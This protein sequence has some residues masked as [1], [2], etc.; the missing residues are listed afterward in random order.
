MHHA[1]GRW[2]GCQ[3]TLAALC[4][5]TKR[6]HVREVAGIGR[7]Q[8]HVGELLGYLK[9]TREVVGVI[10]TGATEIACFKIT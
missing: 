3:R 1:N 7:L 5:W 9:R 8:R 10:R 4:R 2:I 6:K